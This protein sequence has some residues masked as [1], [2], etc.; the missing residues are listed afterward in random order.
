M[1][2]WEGYLGGPEKDPNSCT[3]T[4]RYVCEMV[5]YVCNYACVCVC[6]CVCVYFYNCFSNINHSNTAIFMILFYF[7]E[8]GVQN[9]ISLR[10]HKSRIHPSID[11]THKIIPVECVPKGVPDT[12]CSANHVSLVSVSSHSR[13]Q[14][15]LTKCQLENISHVFLKTIFQCY[16]F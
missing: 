3:Y 11:K 4:F 10:P 14:P 8:R 6:V 13:C 12:D 9:S 16:V 2:F 5:R 7:S 1:L 15:W